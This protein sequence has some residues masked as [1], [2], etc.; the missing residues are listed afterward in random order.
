[1]SELEGSSKTHNHEPVGD[2]D[3]ETLLMMPHVEGAR[4]SMGKNPKDDL[5]YLKRKEGAAK[6][7]SSE[8]GS[9][10]DGKFNPKL[11]KRIK[12]EKP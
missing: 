4:S 7:I 3:T 6:Q 8:D 11:L 1:M 12:V 2:N 9:I 10:K 5:L